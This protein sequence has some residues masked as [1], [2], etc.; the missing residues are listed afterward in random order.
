MSAC[1]AGVLALATLFVVG[2][3]GRAEEKNTIPDDVRA[4]LESAD[5]FEL[6][7]LNPDPREK[8]KDG[9]HGWKV[10]GRTTVKDADTRK[11]LVDALQKGVAENDGT[12][13]ACFNPR[14]GIRVTQGGKTAD[15]VICFECFQASAYLGDK[16][17]K[18]FLVTASPQATFDGVLKD[19]KVPLP[20]PGKPQE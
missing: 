9:F 12:V 6:L 20:G 5:Q 18:S 1:R 16:A 15:I 19:A 13:A 17:T 10:L 3:L 4:V 14:H 11:K 7:S 2:S 8:P